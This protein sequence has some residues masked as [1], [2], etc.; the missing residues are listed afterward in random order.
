MLISKIREIAVATAM[1]AALVLSGCSGGGSAQGSAPPPSSATVVPMAIIMSTSSSSV[2]S[3][4]S[5]T[6]TITATVV[7]V[8]RIAIPGVKVNFVSDTPDALGV[9]SG[10]SSSGG[11]VTIPFSAGMINKTNRAEVVT[12]TVVGTSITAQIP[13]Q[14]VG[15][16]MAL[17]QLDTS[18]PLLATET[19]LSNASKTSITTIQSITLFATVKDAAMAGVAAQSVR[20]SIPAGNGTLSGGTVGTGSATS[21][22]VQSAAK[23]SGTTSSGMFAVGDTTTVTFSPSIAGSVVVTA[24]WLDSNGNVSLSTSTTITVTQSG[25]AFAVTTPSINPSPL[26][27]GTSQAFALTVPTTIS[28]M[29][30]SNVRSEVPVSNVRFST[31]LGT[32]SNGSMI[33]TVAPAANTASETL[34][35]GAASGLA[36]V[37]IDALRDDGTVLAT[38]FQKVSMSAAVNAAANISLQPSVSNVMPSTGGTSNS[39][40]LTAT[41]RDSHNN[42]VSGALVMFKLL[43][44]TGSGEFISPVLVSTDNNGQAVSTFT[45]GA[46]STVGGL[47]IQASVVGSSPLVA[48]VKVINVGGTGVSVSLGHATVISADG[49]NTNYTMPMTVLVVDS[50]GAAVPKATVSLSAWPMTYATGWRDNAC[51]S[52]I[53]GT[54]PNEDANENNILDPGEDINHDGVLTPEHSTGGSVA[55]AD[56]KDL[57]GTVTTD[58]NGVGN[59][60]LTYQKQYAGWIFTRIRAKL[61]VQGT[62]AINT[63][64]FLLPASAADTALTPCPVP[65]SG[66][67]P[68]GTYF[69]DHYEI[70]LANSTTVSLSG[71]TPTKTVTVKACGNAACSVLAVQSP[72]LT[73]LTS[74]LSGTRSST[75]LA[76]LDLTSGFANIALGSSATGTTTLAVS[77]GSYTCSNDGGATTKAG[78]LIPECQIVF[79]P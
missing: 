21:Q 26:T 12:A 24:D 35:A 29:S 2:K 53:T 10:V 7:D 57:S 13:I 59:F 28:V 22:T 73:N 15:S 36:T 55:S 44:P 23:S 68:Y 65:L 60:T 76:P 49:T 66:N 71:T 38:I 67:S 42:T 69:V 72:S 14:V 37:Q 50:T 63:L 30:L 52:N 62:E 25:I 39:A 56:P 34:T 79:A 75:S 47:Q 4:N 11:A 51:K 6:A 70:D 78:G 5:T 27:L 9:S 45:S 48:D 41:V 54:Y 74:S 17:S 32:W 40:T 18:H 58:A 33:N 77:A 46:V 3:D 19:L 61:T 20:F 1:S 8:N 16:T 31:T 64:A 43:N